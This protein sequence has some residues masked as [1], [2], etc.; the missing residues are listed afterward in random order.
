MNAVGD[1]LIISE[2]RRNDPTYPL[3]RIFRKS[4]LSYFSS[5]GKPGFG[6][7]EI[8]SATLVESGPN[9]STFTVYSG[10]SKTLT[11]FSLADTSLLGINQ[12]KQPE[13]LYEVYKMFHATDSTM[14]GIKSIDENRLVEISLKDGKRIAGYGKWEKIPNAD[15]L[16]DY[17]DPIVNFHLGQINKGWFKANRKEGL[18]VTAGV[19]RDRIE[20]FDYNNKKFTVVEGPRLDLP[21]FEIVPSG[22]NSVVIFDIENKYGHRDIYIDDKYIYDLYGGFNEEEI[23]EN[24]V[25]AKTIYILTHS[26]DVVG[27]LHLDISIRGLV[28]DTSLKKIYG[29]TTDKDPGIAVFDLPDEFL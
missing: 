10:M 20:I 11:D 16:I 23:F 4:P 14:L 6:P 29:I 26:G 25:V 8:P 12:Y 9:D 13:G 3:I 28:V 2:N 15:H 21:K 19:Y 18:F 27:M 24:N 17:S 22:A 5:K 7:L 1:F